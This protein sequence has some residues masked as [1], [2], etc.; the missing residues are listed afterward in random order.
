MCNR[1]QKANTW[2]TERV[3]KRRQKE[4]RFI[5]AAIDWPETLALLND[6]CG[7]NNIAVTVKSKQTFINKRLT[8]HVTIR[9]NELEPIGANP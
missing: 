7:N 4:L 1:K 2:L 5:T 6:W 9:F 8:F 3:L